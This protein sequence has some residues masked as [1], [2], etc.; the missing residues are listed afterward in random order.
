MARP[1]RIEYPGAVYHVTARGNARGDIFLDDADRTAF[2]ELLGR[3]IERLGWLVHAYCLMDNHYH[4]LVETPKAN[5]S[6]GMRQLNGTHTQ[7]F[8]RAHGRVGHVFQGRYKAVLVEKEAHMMELS[9]YVVLNPVRAGMVE[10]AG[11]WR[12]SSYR[13]T[14]GLTEAPTLSATDLPRAR[15][16][17]EPAAARA[18]Y[19]RFVADGV[20]GASP[21][22]E[23]RHQVLLGG[24]AF[25]ERMAGLLEG[26]RLSPEV[27][28]PQRRIAAK[29][30][31][32]YETEAAGRDEAIRAAW[33]S[34]TYGLAEMAE[35]FGLHYS[36]VSRIANAGN[37]TRNK[38]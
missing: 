26:G 30:L 14:A 36:W 2:L 25:V 5:L 33:R 11:D 22:E 9:R 13:A 17:R 16:G 24:E 7:R 19:R 10:A 23:L 28:R 8:N 15:F 20:G 4:L 32:E 18:A 21:W 12:W 27:P 34:G 38:T 29:P 35:H 31:S 1:L 37:K 3:A 6:R